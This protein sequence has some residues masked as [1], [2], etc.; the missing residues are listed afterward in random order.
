MRKRHESGEESWLAAAIGVGPF[1]GTNRAANGKGATSVFAR[2]P[3]CHPAGR[4][5]PVGSRHG[6]E[7]SIRVACPRVVLLQK[8]VGD[9]GSSPALTGNLT[10]TEDPREC[11][12]ASGAGS[13]PDALTASKGAEGKTGCRDI[14]SRHRAQITWRSNDRR[15]PSLKRAPTGGRRL[16]SQEHRSFSRSIGANGVAA[17]G[18]SRSFTEASEARSR[19][20]T[21]G[22]ERPSSKAHGPA[23]V[24]LAS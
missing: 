10:N 6:G 23:E 9:V 5:P 22:R 19:W 16:G 14:V 13:N 2:T 3:T 11:R 17:T 4:G 12:S 18:A 15:R 24:V 8:S 7:R 1:I 20:Q 21:M